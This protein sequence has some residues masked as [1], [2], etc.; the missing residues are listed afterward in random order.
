MPFPSL[1]ATTTSSTPTRLHRRS[2]AAKNHHPIPSEKSSLH[3]RRTKRST[4]FSSPKERRR[5]RESGEYG[6]PPAESLHL[7]LLSECPAK[8]RRRRYYSTH[9]RHLVVLRLTFPE[10]IYVNS[11]IINGQTQRQILKF[12]HAPNCRNY[13]KKRRAVEHPI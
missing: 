2:D 12:V 6:P 9:H 7:S 11:I 13:A 8:E 3:I 1:P 5:F 4:N 10:L